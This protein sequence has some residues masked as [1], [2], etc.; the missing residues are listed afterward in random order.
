[1]RNYNNY[2]DY[3]DN[4]YNHNAMHRDEYDD[5]ND[6]QQQQRQRRHRQR[7]MKH[8]RQQQQ[9]QE[10]QRRQRKQSGLHRSETRNIRRRRTQRRKR[11]WQVIP[12]ERTAQTKTEQST[13]I[14]RLVYYLGIFG[15]C[16]GRCLSA[17]CRI[18][19]MVRA[20]MNVPD[21]LITRTLPNMI[22]CMLSLTVIL[23]LYP[24]LA[25]EHASIF[26]S[27]GSRSRC[28]RMH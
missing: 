9:R 4:N 16:S 28:R 21:L 1:M 7:Q 6:K 18:L 22:Y 11:L 20:Q 3:Y 14:C 13:N 27:R 26:G 5:H 24:S 17:C 25:P 2:H 23:P 8:R 12:Q 15:S 19:V 10:Q